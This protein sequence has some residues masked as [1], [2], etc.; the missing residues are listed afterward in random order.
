MVFYFVQR[1]ESLYAIARRYQTTV[2]AIV[3][4]NRL[5][6]PNAIC[7]G[8]ALIIPRPGEIPSPPP[9][10]IVHLVRPGETVFQLAAKF[11]ASAPEILKANQIAHPEFILPGQ[12]LVIPEPEEIGDEWPMLGRTPGRSGSGPVVL[13]GVP[14]PG[15]SHTPR[16]SAGVLPSAPVVRYDRVFVGLGDGYYYSFDR[17]SGRVK[18]RIPGFGSAGTKDLGDLPLA[19]PTVYEGLVYLCGPDGVVRAVDAYSGDVVWKL[20]VQVRNLS[21]PAAREGIVYFA[22]GGRSVY[23]VEAKTG[24][25][26]W[27]ADTEADVVHPVAVGDDTVWAITSA[28]T[29]VALHSQTGERKWQQPASIVTPPIFG[30]VVLLC[31]GTAFDPNTG[32]PVWRTEAK[33]TP[34][35]W[36][37]TAVYPDRALDLITGEERWSNP[38]TGIQLQNLSVS[39]NA[40]L[41]IG[42]DNRL[43]A[44]AAEDGLLEWSV[45]VGG[46]SHHPVTCTHGQIFL[47]LQDGSLRSLR[48]KDH[49]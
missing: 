13:E 17:S 43:Y 42:S 6:D 46:E 16:K 47:S 41:A 30:E 29:L 19:T 31:G 38:V 28:R 24:A 11:G 34:V 27:S 5:E 4:A 49:T 32:T 35:V 21:S 15:W 22:G 1:G 26:A 2:H 3:S 9:G 36:A 10:G 33:G 39:G 14:L 40:W 48:L 45:E 37:D 20:T 44:G 18:W 25:I 12:Q 23:A 7:P 8:Q